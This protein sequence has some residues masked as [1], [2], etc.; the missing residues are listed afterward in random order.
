MN[1]ISVE[2]YDGKGNIQMQQISVVLN[3]GS[4]SPSSS[5][6][7]LSVTQLSSNKTSPQVVGTTITFTAAATGGR[8]PYQ[9]KWWLYNGTS[10]VV[11]R[12]WS[13]SSSHSWTPT[14]AG[15]AY[16]I[17]VWVRDSTTTAD[18]GTVNRSMPFTISST[19][20]TTWALRITSLTANRTSP[21]AKGTSITFTVAASGGVSP[22]SF[23]WLIY[24]GTSWR[25]ARN[26]GTS[27]NFTWTPTEASSR[28][29]VGVWARDATTTADVGSVNYS[30]PFAISP[31][32]PGGNTGVSPY[33]RITGL[34]PNLV[35]PTAAGTA[36]T[37][38][39]SAAG[40]S[41]S[42][43]FK[44]WVYNGTTWTIVRDW[45]STT[46]YTWTPPYAGAA[47][48]MAIWLRQTGSSDNT[49]SLNYSI[50]YPVN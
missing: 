25:V 41:G 39:A 37:F 34:A 35:S 38:T 9:Y 46:T 45:S 47:W 21:Q 14:Q 31:L 19:I 48:R 44:W 50:P 40:G 43:Q 12:D 30:V 20:S 24:D 16:Q 10:W 28:Y 42:Y 8:S 18:V 15:S 33:L 5:T 13:T 27:T 7:P 6:A 11:L 32:G 22:H 3:A 1:T 26:W 4:S 29:R 2:A 23:K 49:G 36:V 17:R